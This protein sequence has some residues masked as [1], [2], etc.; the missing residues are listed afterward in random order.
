MTEH[1][2][3]E[4]LSEHNLKIATAESCTGGLVA[5]LLCDISGISAFFEEGFITYSIKAKIKNLGVSED[6][7]AK[8][9]VV[10]RETAEEMAIGAAKR[11]NAN[12]AV[13]T[14]GIAGPTGGTVETPVGCV[15]IGCVVND[16]VYS[17]R[18]MF[19]GSRMEIRMQAAAYAL[20]MLCNQ[21]ELSIKE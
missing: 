4:M 8:Y 18:L 10:S 6:T 9:G 14:T 21:I 16:R 3:L 5:G 19:E 12:C 7:I 13:S 15:C 1:K 20:E 11:A 2:L 17:E